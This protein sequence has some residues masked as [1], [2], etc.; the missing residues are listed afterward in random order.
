[1]SDFKLKQHLFFQ[2]N[3]VQTLWDKVLVWIKQKI[4]VKLIFSWK[5]IEFGLILKDKNIYLIYR[6][7][8]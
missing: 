5:I 7:I 4:S 3:L 1:M 2:R 6:I 8:C